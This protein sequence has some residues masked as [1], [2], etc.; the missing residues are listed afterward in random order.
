[1]SDTFK[2]WATGFWEGEGTVLI[3]KS[4]MV[5]SVEMT[6]VDIQP[7]TLFQQVWGGNVYSYPKKG[8]SWRAYQRWV[9][10]GPG[11]AAFLID[12]RPFVMR[13]IMLQKVDL[14]IAFQAQKT[15]TWDNRTDAYRQRQE[16]FR[17]RMKELNAIG[18]GR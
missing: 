10:H 8:S 3:T 1:M 12:I 6:Q 5:L 11:A 15:S 17:M 9:V 14:G 4:R 18:V 7:I 2:A 16:D 13:Q